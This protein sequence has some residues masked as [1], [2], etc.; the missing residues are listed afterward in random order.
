ME[1]S[2]AQSRKAE[3]PMA[4]AAP[5]AELAAEPQESTVAST[6][7]AVSQLVLSIAAVTLSAAV[8]VFAA[9]TKRRK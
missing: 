6:I 1:L 3:E 2:C 9:R 4:E 8:V 7:K 5:E